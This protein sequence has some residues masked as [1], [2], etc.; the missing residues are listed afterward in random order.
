MM[1]KKDYLKA[2]KIVHTFAK[3]HERYILE[4]AF[5]ELF[6]DDNSKFDED[7]FREA[8]QRKDK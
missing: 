6:S 3:A 2:V 8:C 1:H 7:K 5:V 4:T